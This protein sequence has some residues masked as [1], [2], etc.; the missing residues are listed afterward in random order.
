[1]QA[2]K[3]NL[4]EILSNDIRLVA[5]LFQRRYVWKQE[6]NWEPLWQALVEVFDRR[7]SG[8]PQRPYFLGALVFDNLQGATGTVPTRE[9]IDG[10]QRMATLQ[11]FMQVARELLADSPT[12]VQV[13]DRLTRN[14]LGGS[15]D[16]QFKF[17]PTNIDREP[18]RAVMAAE[19]CDG[20]MH[21]A[22]HFFSSELRDWLNLDGTDTTGRASALALGLTSDLVFVVV[23]LDNDDD[24]QLI[25]ET[26]NSLG[27]PLQ[28]SDL[29][30][31]LLFRQATAEKLDTDRLYHDYWK[32]FES[33]SSYW[34]ENVTIGRRE[35]PRLD[36]FLQ[37]YLTFRLGREP[38]VPHLFREY[39]DALQ[40]GLFG[41]TEEAL[42]DF[43]H[44]ARLFKEFD[45]AYDGVPGNL[46]HVLSVLDLSV[47]TPLVLGIYANVEAGTERDAMLSTI[48]SYLIRRFLCCLL[49]KRYNQI[50]ADLI[51]NLN[52]NGWS[53]EALR[54][55][56]L[57]FEGNSSV[58]PDDGF[59]KWRTMERDAYGDLR[60]VGI[61]Y[62]FG[63]IEA[64]LR[65]EKAELPWNPRSP[66]TIEHLM[67]QRWEEHWP[68][69][70]PSDE[71]AKNR[72]QSLIDRM[73]NLT[74]LTKKLNSSVSNAPWSVKRGRLNE[75]TV[76][77][78]NS[79]ITG[80][81]EWNEES[82]QDRS[83][84]LANRFCT[85]WPR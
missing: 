14:I 48:E 28:P 19:P 36:V 69:P 71:E 44:H 72:R 82:I 7:L 29:V 5:P 63:R 57:S 47:P 20:L 46:R 21:E 79:G 41:T 37:F 12:S 53:N 76:L 10:Q 6:Q 8:A 45:R 62:V 24:G 54:K 61:S 3:R 67:P 68:L 13:L 33:E 31:N 11:I 39:R 23:D 1:M 65:T 84:D 80:R 22:R 30:K 9:I 58:W 38:L 51:A 85:L 73:G 34:G 27:T 16:E 4:G 50:V 32:A 25:F 59:V 49:T 2:N 15:G 52:K 70:S 74:V 60:G 56:L 66:L 81:S 35:R 64:S 26:L 40:D 43:A 83:A 75:H 78:I 17:W 42:A 18:F 77:L 55:A